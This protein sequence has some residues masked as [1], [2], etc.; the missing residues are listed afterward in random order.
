MLEIPIELIFFLLFPFTTMEFKEQEE[1][2]M[3]AIIKV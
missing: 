2:D 1:K 3:S